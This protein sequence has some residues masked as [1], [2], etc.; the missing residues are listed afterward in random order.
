MQGKLNYA[1]KDLRLDKEMMEKINKLSEDLNIRNT[2]VARILLK[3]ALS[4]INL[5]DSYAFGL[6]SQKK[7]QKSRQIRSKND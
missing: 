4:R 3:D 7:N 2:L 6:V 5:N 1:L